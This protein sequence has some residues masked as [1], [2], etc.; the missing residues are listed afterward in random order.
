MV[1]IE[2]S[3]EVEKSFKCSICPST[4]TMKQNL[5]QHITTIH[6]EKKTTEVE[7]KQEK[8][9]FIEINS[10]DPI[11]FEGQFHK[12]YHLFFLKISILTGNSDFHLFVLFKPL[13]KNG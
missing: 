4:F 10:G 11:Y 12:K 7:I 8:M 1:P 6:D 9:D 2:D 3:G 13:N 5:Y